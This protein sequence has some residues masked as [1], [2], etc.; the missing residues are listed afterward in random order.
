[1]ATTV[2]HPASRDE[3]SVLIVHL[4]KAK[5]AREIEGLAD[6]LGAAGD[7]RAIRPLLQRLG[8]RQVYD[9]VDTEDAVCGALVVLGVMCSP[10]NQIF[11]FLPRDV[12][13]E[14]VIDVI[15]E[16]GMAIPYR[17]FETKHV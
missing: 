11:H 9:D 15:R 16:L 4:I 1:M 2:V 5:S 10:G 6:L 8:D 14:D 12:L 3:V 17:Y 7:R 13:A